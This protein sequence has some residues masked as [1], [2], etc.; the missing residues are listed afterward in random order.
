MTHRISHSSDGPHSDS[1]NLPKLPFKYS[2]QFMVPVESIPGKQ[3]STVILS[4]SVSPDFVVVVCPI[5]FVLWIQE[6]PG[7]FRL[8]FSQLFLVVSLGVM[9]SKLFIYCSWNQILDRRLHLCCL[10]C[11][12]LFF[13]S[14]YTPLTLLLYLVQV[15]IQIDHL[16]SVTVSHKG[17]DRRWVMLFVTKSYLTKIVWTS[18]STSR[19]MP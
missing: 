18:N 11:W 16:I 14:L 6:K 13:K 1:S 12:Q 9:T 4:L 19:S 5:T 15:L 17:S 3:I 8:F 7:I 2:Y 10:M